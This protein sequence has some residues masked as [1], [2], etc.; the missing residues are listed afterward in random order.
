MEDLKRHFKI[1]EEGTWYEIPKYRVVENV[2]LIE[3]GESTVINFV[4]GSKLGSDNIE[5]K[6]GTLHEHLLSV[7]IHDLKYKNNLLPSRET[8]TTITKLEE[9]LFW[10]EERQRARVAQ[11]IAG[12]YQKAA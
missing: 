8:A 10:A 4:R 3:T 6:D 9:A 7:M 5:P 2:G 12:T 11:G 1:V